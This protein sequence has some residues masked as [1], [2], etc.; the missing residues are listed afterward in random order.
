M[1]KVSIIVPVYNT[2]KYLARCIDSILAQT[3]TDF[4]LILVNDGSKDNSG[5]ICDEYAQKDSRIIVIHKE[6]GGVSSARNKGLDIAQGE[7]ISFVDSD[8]W[9]SSN[10]L[11]DF[12]Y[13]ADLMIC[14][15]EYIGAKAEINSPT[16]MNP[17]NN[18]YAISQWFYIN[19]NNIYITTVA[20]SIF[21]RK[22]ITNQ[23]LY[24]DNKLKYGEDTDFM[25][26][27]LCF[28]STIDLCHAPNYKYVIESPNCDKYT[29]DAISYHYHIS[30]LNNTISKIE[31]YLN[32]SLYKLKKIFYQKYL[33]LFYSYLNAISISEAR[34]ELTK[35]NKLHLIKFCGNLNWKE[36]IYLRLITFSPSL[37]YHRR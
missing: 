16:N 35:Y 4:E 25:Y 12:S 2:E 1:P 18:A 19:C 9:I 7:W 34:E 3:F 37:F 20:G 10:Y 32:L 26:R 23:T 29:L 28:C 5:K 8:D 22:I 13:D 30:T 6:N 24:F 31:Q 21:K 15:F 17:L 33:L 27:Y 36:Y 14:G 11:S